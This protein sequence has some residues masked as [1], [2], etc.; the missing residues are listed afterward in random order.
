MQNNICF[1]KGLQNMV[2]SVK[3]SYVNKAA[4]NQGIDGWA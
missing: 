3:Q 2:S 4:C 1:Q